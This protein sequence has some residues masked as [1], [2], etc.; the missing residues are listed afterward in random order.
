MDF[1]DWWL[2]VWVINIFIAKEDES[3]E[4]KL[5]VFS[6]ADMIQRDKDL[7]GHTS[8]HDGSKGVRLDQI[9][10]VDDVHVERVYEDGE[11]HDFVDKQRNSCAKFT[12]VS[13]K[14]HQFTEVIIKTHN[15]IFIFWLASH[16]NADVIEVKIFEILEELNNL[17]K[18]NTTKITQ[19]HSKSVTITISDHYHQKED[20][21][22]SNS[23]ERRVVVGF[24]HIQRK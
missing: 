22:R 7:D 3:M 1:V 24:N 23:C 5:D 20:K 18:T 10:V 11:A 9:D 14:V 4:E 13:T 17:G 2:E 12:K 19:T 16:H 21:N 8:E 15:I 6:S